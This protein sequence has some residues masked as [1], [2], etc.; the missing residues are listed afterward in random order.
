MFKQ[1]MILRNTLKR[2]GFESEEVLP[3]RAFGAV[4]ARAGVG[5][6][7]FLVQLALYNLLREKKVL[8]VSLTDPVDKV[9]VWYSEIF[10][11]I[12][13][14]EGNAHDIALLESL[15]PNRFIMTFHVDGFSLPKFE[16][17]LKELSQQ[18]IFSPSVVIMDGL[19]F[20]ESRQAD[21]YGLKELAEKNG[22]R[23]WFAV[24]TH[25]EE[26]HDGNLFPVSFAP[27]ADL[28]D[29]VFELRPDHADVYISTLRGGKAG[30]ESLLLDPTTML[31]KNRL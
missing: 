21:V 26:Q 15:L 5:K 22:L 3:E 31:I 16:E 2:L 18:G 13:F 20:E 10:R 27:F 9:N 24:Q 30:G 6:T 29:V 23:M 19:A 17:R 28:F 8:H 1:E 25:R 14:Q 12:S 7:A 11:R 4:L